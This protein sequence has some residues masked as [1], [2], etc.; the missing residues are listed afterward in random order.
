MAIKSL[1]LR[2][3]LIFWFPGSHAIVAPVVTELPN[4]YVF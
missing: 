3:R 1:H 2:F 4:P